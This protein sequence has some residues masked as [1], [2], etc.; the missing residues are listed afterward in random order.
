LDQ[1]DGLQ[2]L[3]EVAR[4]LGRDTP[5]GL[6]H[7]RMCARRR[8]SGSEAAGARRR[9]RV[10][11]AP[12]DDRTQGDQHGLA[13]RPLGL[14][15]AVGAGLRLRNDGVQAPVHHALEVNGKVAN[16]ARAPEAALPPVVQQRPEALVSRMVA[17]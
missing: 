13:V 15:S 9:V 5:T 3:E 12:L 1:R 4:R 7:P 6:C 14:I 2:T 8:G 16:P 10:P 17:R 11:L